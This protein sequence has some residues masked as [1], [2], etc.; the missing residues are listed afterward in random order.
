M[1]LDLTDDEAFTL[2]E[3]LAV[4]VELCS[5]PFSEKCVAIQRKMNAIGFPKQH[6]YPLEIP[7]LADAPGGQG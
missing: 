2:D 6:V 3:A 5:F 7:P 1:Q 4:A